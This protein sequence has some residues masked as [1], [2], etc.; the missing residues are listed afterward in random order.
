MSV[1]LSIYK[2]IVFSIAYIGYNALQVFSFRHVQQ[3]G[4]V[5]RLSAG[6][7]DSQIPVD[8]A[9]R[10]CHDFQVLGRAHMVGA[11]AGNED[12]TWPQHL[13][14]AQVELFVPAQRGLQIAL[15]FG[16]GRRIE[17]DGVIPSA[18]VGIV[19]QQVKGIGLYPFDIAA[20]QRGI[21]PLES[22]R[23]PKS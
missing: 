13:E 14:R 3:D 11:A 8:V 19:A 7:D 6:L 16:E 2:T 22:L 9:G 17:D 18:R 15:A 20:I 12:A 4:M 10:L 21:V 23:K 1:L 5:L